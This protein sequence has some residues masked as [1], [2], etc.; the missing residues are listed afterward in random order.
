M[1]VAVSLSLVLLDCSKY[2]IFSFI[3]LSRHSMLAAAIAA[4][5]FFASLHCREL[6]LTEVGGTHVFGIIERAV[7]IS[8]AVLRPAFMLDRI[9]PRT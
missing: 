4:A 3:S 9:F 1:I 2:R 6:A 5:S 7:L 8:P